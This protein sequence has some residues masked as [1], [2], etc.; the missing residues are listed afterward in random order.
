MNSSITLCLAANDGD[1]ELVEQLIESGADVN[2]HNPLMGAAR[3]GHE[4]VVSILLANGAVVDKTFP[5]GFTALMLAAMNGHNSAV[6]ALLAGGA[7]VDK[8]DNRGITALMR[9]TLNGHESVVATLL[10]YNADVNKTN[11]N[12]WSPLLYAS[13]ESRETI[14]R[15]LHSRADIDTTVRNKNGKDCLDVASTEAIKQLIVERRFQK[16]KERLIN[17]G[18]AFASKQF[19]TLVLVHIYEQSIYFPESK[20]Q[21]FECWEILK[22]LKH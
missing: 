21:L 11:K 17:I 6:V 1:S 15:L 2:A 19:P 22:V 3:K 20:I 18:L 12:G 9:A 16:E 8:H 10:D 14:V 7:I 4:S 5:C 13:Q